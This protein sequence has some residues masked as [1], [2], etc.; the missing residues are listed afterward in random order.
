MPFYLLPQS[1]ALPVLLLPLPPL[2][3][4]LLPAQENRDLEEAVEEVD[5]EQGEDDGEV[6]PPYEGGEEVVD[7]EQSMEDDEVMPP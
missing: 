6:M 1:V 3:F 2:P 5:E 4:S 7:E